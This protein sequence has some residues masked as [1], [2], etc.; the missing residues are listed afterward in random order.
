MF[1]LQLSIKG[2][3]TSRELTVISSIIRKGGKNYIFILHL[4]QFQN[5][6]AQVVEVGL[7]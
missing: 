1:L 7:K 3:I 5:D 4:L 6:P 2:K